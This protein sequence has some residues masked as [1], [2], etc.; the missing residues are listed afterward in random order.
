[1]GDQWRN[2]LR[3]SVALAALVLLLW[4]AISAC[5]AEPRQPNLSTRE[6][7]ARSVMAAA[8]SGSAE[9]VVALV[10]PAFVNAGPEAQQL[11]ASTRG[12][13]P[14][15]W[16]LGISSD[17]P[18][19]ANVTARRDGD[20]G[21]VRYV[22]SWNDERWTLAMGEPKNQPSGGASA[23]TRLIGPSASAKTASSST[24]QPPRTPP[25][26]A[27][28]AGAGLAC[29]SFTSTSGYAHGQD[30]YWLTSTPLHVSFDLMGETTT[31][32]VRMPCGVLNVPVSVDDFGLIPVPAGTAGSADGCA[33]PDAEHR[34]WTSAY[35]KQ[36][37]VYQLDSSE[38]V[39]TNEL[40]QIRFKQD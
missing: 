8:V 33:G 17:S 2:R 1:M 30:L 16:Q 15:S 37:A 21:T 4:P 31:M 7:F 38:L 20:S 39:L 27:A 10:N 14:G 26:P 35:F 23:G 29:H 12:W 5:F 19:I 9:S 3:P 32:V 24:S 34:S 22:I 13:A 40:G 28:C 25:P 18:E 11:V 36:P 6:E